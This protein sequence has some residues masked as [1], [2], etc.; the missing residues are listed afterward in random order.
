VISAWRIR[1]R[2]EIANVE[3]LVRCA[4]EAATILEENDSAI[5]EMALQV[6][7][8][9]VDPKV[10]AILLGGLAD[11]FIKANSLEAGSQL[12]ILAFETASI[13]GR[14]TM[15]ELLTD[16]AE[17]LA[18]LDRGE[19]LWKLWNEFDTVDKWFPRESLFRD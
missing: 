3:Y 14:D 5:F 12:L 1:K 7:Q 9:N 8:K 4:L 13:A 16:V 10:R 19:L 2:T 18:S 17:A 6:A 11:I 15:L